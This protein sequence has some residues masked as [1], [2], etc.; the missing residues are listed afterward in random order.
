MSFAPC[1]SFSTSADPLSSFDSADFLDQ[2]IQRVPKS[3]A[4]F[5][6]RCTG[7][8]PHSEGVTLEFA[9]GTSAE[10]DVLVASDGIKSSVRRAM[11]ER[12]GLDLQKQQ[13]VYSEWVAVSPSRLSRFGSG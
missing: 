11:Y 13:A 10:A 5:K 3:I 6:H 4:H 9:D 1:S 8:K 12:K 2:L 7:Y